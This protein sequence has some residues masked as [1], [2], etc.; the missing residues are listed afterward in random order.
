MERPTISSASTVVASA[1]QVS[2]GVEGDA[3][4]LNFDE[5][6]YYGLDQVGARVWELIG[7]PITFAELRDRLVSEYEV[8][9]NRC[10]QDLQA[11]LSD[12]VS[13]GL[14]EVSDAEPA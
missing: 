1:R 8:E 9:P 10:E 3:V 6:V 5:G 11:L 13:A 7:D 4:I 12:L 14:V 2:T